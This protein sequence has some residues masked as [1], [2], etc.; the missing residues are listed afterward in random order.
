M[1]GSFAWSNKQVPQDRKSSKR[2]HTAREPNYTNK[3]AVI[4]KQVT[5]AAVLELYGSTD[6]SYS[7]SMSRTRFKS[8]VLHDA[9]GLIIDFKII[10][11]SLDTVGP[12][13]LEKSQVLPLPQQI[14]LPC[15]LPRNSTG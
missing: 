13:F 10:M 7:N 9:F 12:Q 14:R 11:N 5:F 6:E 4:A 3:V 1:I 8:R 15:R 2:R